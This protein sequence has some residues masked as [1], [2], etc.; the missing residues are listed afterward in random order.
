MTDVEQRYAQWKA[1]KAQESSADDSV[2]RRYQAWLEKK[3]R[4][5]FTDT[6]STRTQRPISIFR[7]DQDTAQNWYQK[8]ADV[9]NEIYQYYSDW[10]PQNEQKYQY[11]QNTTSGLLSDAD[12]WRT[13]FASN[14]EALS[15]IDD[16]V[17]ALETTNENLPK[18]YNHWAQW[19]TEGEYIKGTPENRE[20]RQRIYEDNLVKIKALQEEMARLARAQASNN[21]AYSFGDTSMGFFLP[22]TDPS[23]SN[24]IKDIKMQIEALETENRQYERGEAGFAMKVLDDYYLAYMNDPGFLAAASNRNYHNASV[25]DL[26]RY[27]ELNDVQNWSYDED[28]NLRSADGALIAEDGKGGYY[29]PDSVGLNIVND[30]LGL[31]INATEED[32]RTGLSSSGIWRD[33]YKEGSAKNWDE[34]EENE[35]TLY[36]GLHGTQGQ[37]AAEKFLDDIQPL[38]DQRATHSAIEKYQ[39]QYDAADSFEKV[40]LN[41][42]TIPRQLESNVVGFLEDNIAT[43]RGGDINPYSSAHAGMHFTQTIRGKTAQELDETGFKIPI[44]NFTLGDLYQSGMSMVDSLAAMGVGGSYGGVLLAMGAAE[45]EA[46]ELYKQGASVE[47]IALGAASAGAAE[48][49]FES[50]SIGELDA[51]KNMRSTQT[52]AQI[53]KTMLVQGG[54]EASEEALTEIAN[55]VSNAFIMGTQSDW[56][57]LMEES[58]G[59]LAKA[60]LQKTLDVLHAGMG[61]FLSGVGSGGLVGNTSYIA[62][63]LSSSESSDKSKKSAD[64]ASTEEESN[65]R[66]RYSLRIRH[67][68][69][70]VEELS[71]ARELTDAEALQYLNQAKTGE[72]RRDSYIPVRKDTPQVIIDTLKQ[73]NEQIPNFSL[74]M[75]AQ[76][77]RQAM[78]NEMPGNKNGKYGPNIRRHA[79]QPDDIIEIMHNLDDPEMIIYQTNRTGKSGQTLP[80]N[81]SVFVKYQQGEAEGL[82]VI[83]FEGSINPE[84]IGYAVPYSCHGIRTGRRTKWCGFRLC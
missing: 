29:N 72:I 48:L 31:F 1:R 76:K 79:L 55:T 13:Q 49:I 74:V 43:L 37:E 62:N 2:E 6:G 64:I 61:G 23:Y 51:I 53:F 12:K 41:A 59:N 18:V 38:L 81:V 10:K 45:S 78:G 75:Q 47:Q 21:S 8:S 27:K 40:L 84:N 4:S 32:K 20:K 68:N 15:A 26:L 63:R 44:V 77:A 35:L 80:N 42:E 16:V 28:G 34:L 46:Y 33:I 9:V 36:Y 19:D 3:K 14:D 11:F 50:I 83:E 22:V 56:E 24:R 60:L 17:S 7:K 58:D 70:T 73:V 30:K 67:S 71:N 39:S 65:E 52:V 25:E 66:P 5:S 69:G 82:S 54:V 57:Q